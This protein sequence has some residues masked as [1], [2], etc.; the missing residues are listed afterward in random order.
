MTHSW[1]LFLLIPLAVVLLHIHYI[2]Y[3]AKM[4]LGYDPVKPAGSGR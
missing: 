4:V 3:I 1:L 2:E